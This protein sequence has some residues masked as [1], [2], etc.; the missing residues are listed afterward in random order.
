MSPRSPFLIDVS[1]LARRP[2]RVRPV[3][4]ESPAE[5]AVGLSRTLPEP[6]LVA[7]LEL[8]PAAGGVLV[9]GRVRFT[10]EHTCHRCLDPVREVMSIDVSELFAEPGVDE[11]AEYAVVGEELDLEPLIRDEI[12]L[13]MPLLP[14]C[15]GE[16]AGPAA[17][18][19]AVDEDAADETGSPF[20]GLRDLFE[21]D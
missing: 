14:T 6:P 13:A 12:L 16:C 10:A 1:D 4:I 18:A 3:T 11:D 2:G 20:A 19:P 17:G 9:R 15:A 21:Q 8:A 7:S 5:W